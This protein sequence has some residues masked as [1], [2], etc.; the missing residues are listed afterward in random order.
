MT[1]SVA[2]IGLGA[3]GY[4]MAAHLPKYF[5]K[6]YVWNRSFDKAE[7]HATEYLLKLFRQMLSFLACLPGM[8]L[9]H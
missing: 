6:V 5:E 4:R 9:K 1:Q 7:Q 3:M 8:T 2:F